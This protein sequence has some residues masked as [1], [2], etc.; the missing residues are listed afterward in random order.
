M[1][2]AGVL[3]LASL[4]TT[5]QYVMYAIDSICQDSCTSSPLRVL[6]YH[7]FHFLSI[8]R[9]TAVLPSCL[10]FLQPFLL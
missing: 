10:R 3:L 6:R 5:T 1:H 8:G 7:L 9:S 4:T 2:Q